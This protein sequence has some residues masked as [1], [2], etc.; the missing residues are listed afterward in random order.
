[1]GGRSSDT[2]RAPASTGGTTAARRVARTVARTLD[3]SPANP[4]FVEAAR[5]EAERRGQATVGIEFNHWMAWASE[6]DDSALAAQHLGWVYRHCVCHHARLTSRVAVKSTTEPILASVLSARCHPSWSAKHAV[7]IS[8]L[9]TYVCPKELLR[10]KFLHFLLA[11]SSISP[12]QALN[13][14]QS[15]FWQYSFLFT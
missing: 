9:P 10:L 2:T 13:I 3:Q 8:L 15:G 5:R 14:S 12:A 11:R 1:M 7:E 6:F 4:R